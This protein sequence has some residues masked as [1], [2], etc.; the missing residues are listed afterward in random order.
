MVNAD[1]QH[2]RQETPT[3]T[4]IDRSKWRTCGSLLE[5]HSRCEAT[6]PP[7]SPSSP[8]VAAIT[9]NNKRPRNKGVRS[10]VVARDQ[11]RVFVNGSCSVNSCGIV[12]VFGSGQICMGREF[13]LKLLIIVVE[14]LLHV[15]LRCGNICEFAGLV[16]FLV[17][18]SS[19]GCDA[20]GLGDIVLLGNDSDV[21]RS[22]YRLSSWYEGM[23][24]SIAM[25]YS[26]AG[27]VDNAHNVFDEMLER[28]RLDFWEKSLFR[29][30][31][32]MWFLGGGSVLVAPLGF[33]GDGNFMVVAGG[34]FADPDPDPTPE[35]PVV[36]TPEPLSV[37]VPHPPSRYEAQ[38]IRDWKT[39]LKYLSNHKPPLTLSRCSGA[40]V[41]E[42][43]RYLDRFGKTKVHVTGCPYF[44]HPNTPAPCSCQLKQAWGSLD[45]LIGRLRA[46]YEENSEQPESN[47]FGARAVRI[48][49]R[50][51]RESQS[52]AR[53]VPY[54][55]K[56][57]RPSGGGTMA[58]AK[59]LVDDLHGGGGKDISSS[60]PATSTV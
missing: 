33:Y 7:S 6:T 53:G 8:N 34:G 32:G 44:G 37:S 14:L 36:P 13:V 51:V 16:E 41:I 31:W 42:F 27:M 50:E 46:A 2:T 60:A 26:Q 23:W 30:W 52:K 57:K 12:L 19:R 35:L 25:L 58:I 43:L 54:E 56:R 39:F 28:K 59:V 10:W 17:V 24:V 15:M 45:A 20:Y 5:H 9:I 49:L 18:T 11:V 29:F 4:V 55:K 40:H 47:P 1:P 22:R 3:S 21:C 38:K 48:Y